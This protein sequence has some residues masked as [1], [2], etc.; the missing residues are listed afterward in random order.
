MTSKYDAWLTNAPD[1]SDEDEYIDNRVYELLKEED[2]DPTDVAHM[3]EAI[4]EADEA[5]QQT[6]RDFIEQDKWQELGRKLFCLSYEYMEKF[7]TS[8]AQHEIQQG[9]HL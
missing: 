5:T 4:S 8:Q 2:Y 7:A 9:Y 6:I 1:S 3:A